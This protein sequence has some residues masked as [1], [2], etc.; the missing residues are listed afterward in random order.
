VVDR[1]L[2]R[3]RT[4]VAGGLGGLAVA[5]LAG[6]CDPGEDLAPAQDEPSGR[7][8]TPSSQASEQ[9]PEETPDEAL[10]TEVVGQLSTAL[11]L[12]LSSRKAP[13]LRQQLSPIVRAHR[14][15][16][17]AL[18]GDLPA[19]PPAGPPPDA[20]AA[21][22]AVRRSERALQAAL[23]DAAGRAESGALARLLA[24]ISAS[25]TQHLTLIPGGAP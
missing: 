19:E 24:S 21:L 6:G 9:T 5:V 12:L 14:S 13:G 20:A 8:A 11:A 15:H 7:S 16:L 23:A 2:L 10:L 25:A 3:R 1:P 22:Q 18:D 4:A 17:E